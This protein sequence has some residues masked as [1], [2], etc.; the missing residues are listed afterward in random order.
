MSRRYVARRVSKEDE[1][2]KTC[3]VE[4]ISPKMAL[5]YLAKQHEQQRHVDDARVSS[6]ADLMK[7]GTWLDLIGE[8]IIFDKSGFLVNGAHRLGAIVQ[9][10]ISGQKFIVIRNAGEDDILAMDQGRKR[11]ATQMFKMAGEE[12]PKGT[13]GFVRAFYE[14][15]GLMSFIWDMKRIS[16]GYDKIKAGIDWFDG[17]IHALKVTGSNRLFTAPIAAAFIRAYYHQ[18]PRAKVLEEEESSLTGMLKRHFTG[19]STRSPIVRFREWILNQRDMGGGRTARNDIYLKATMA[20]RNELEFLESGKNTKLLK[21]TKQDLW[22]IKDGQKLDRDPSTRGGG[23]GGKVDRLIKR[24]RGE[25]ETV[26]QVMKELPEILALQQNGAAKP[27]R[28]RGRNI[29]KRKAKA[30]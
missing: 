20:I 2:Q 9:S 6:Y 1:A 29:R 4:G 5:R 26:D 23:K 30:K 24:L 12:V 18:W 25:Q 17:I 10:G 16:D 22:P 7:E 19:D 15:P 21:R 27:K 28:K 13:P 14:L 11:T 3:K 8:P